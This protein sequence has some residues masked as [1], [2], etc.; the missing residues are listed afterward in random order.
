MRPAFYW[1]VTLAV[2]TAAPTPAQAKPPAK[3]PAEAAAEDPDVLAKATNQR[4]EFVRV[5]PELDGSVARGGRV[6]LDLAGVDAFTAAV[7]AREFAQS[8]RADLVERAS[9]AEATELVEQPTAV[10][11]SSKGAPPPPATPT[12][13]RLFELTAENYAVEG[14]S[15]SQWP[16]PDYFAALSTFTGA[17]GDD[18][19]PFLVDNPTGKG[20]RVCAELRAVDA[21]TGIVRWADIKCADGDE[22]LAD[23]RAAVV[24]SMREA[25]LC[26]RRERVLPLPVTSRSGAGGREG[27]GSPGHSDLI[28]DLAAAGCGI[29]DVPPGADDGGGANAWTYAAPGF[30]RVGQ[31]RIKGWPAAEFAVQVRMTDDETTVG[32]LR[33]DLADMDPQLLDPDIALAKDD[34]VVKV[35]EM[36]VKAVDLATGRIVASATVRTGRSM[37]AGLLAGVVA[38]IA[39][40]RAPAGWVEVHALPVTATIKVD[41]R[42]LATPEGIGLAR[43]EPGSHQAELFLSNAKAE[44]Q[45]SVSVKAFDFGIL[46]I[47]APFGAIEVTTTPDAADVA[48]DGNGWGK[49]KVTRTVN[50]GEHTVVASLPACGATEQKVD[51]E[52]GGALT[53]VHL[54]LPGFV[55]AS[56]VPAEA[57]ILL[58]GETKGQ[59]SARV[60]G[61][62]AGEHQLTYRLEGY[63]DHTVSI[64][65]PSC[66]TAR[67]AYQMSGKVEVASVPAG[68]ELRVDGEAK[69]RTPDKVTLRPGEYEVSCHWC[70]YGSAATTVN[71]EAGVVKPVSLD[72]DGSGF[73]FAIGPRVGLGLDGGNAALVAGGDLGAW[74]NGKVGAVAS[75]DLALGAPS[76]LVGLGGAYRVLAPS[77]G[78]SMPVGARAVVDLGG[79][80]PRPGGQATIGFHACSGPSSAWVID[81][82]VGAIGGDN[83]GLLASVRG[84]IEWR[85][86]APWKVK[87]D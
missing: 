52:A 73:R 12:T 10:S 59:G 20:V 50:G 49:A 74:F 31:T 86:G 47:A 57:T 77:P 33:A 38:D 22:A 69:G 55:E 17:D 62:T 16:V 32:D 61:V 37:P 46:V 56:V 13:T 34:A 21:G 1:L 2:A 71:V 18:S 85:T 3:A 53:R 11:T 79:A 63:R 8:G 26:A 65:V 83:P 51:V 44:K 14:P 30:D 9:L 82:A 64:E 68:A 7:F 78:W 67:D 72:L 70:E 80:S 4:V 23:A 48:V 28:R 66:D 54:R 75:V 29:V 76:T 43:L 36:K 58:D 45:K 87:S 84:G 24:A 39:L 42:A 27:E 5:A 15:Q 19:R 35:R 40:G 81:A 6:V 60:E 41:R 25:G